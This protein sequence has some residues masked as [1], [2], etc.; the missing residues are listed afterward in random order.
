MMTPLRDVGLGELDES[1]ADTMA[2]GWGPDVETLDGVGCSMKPANN[3]LAK[4]SN[5]D[6][7][8]RDSSLHAWNA[9]ALCPGRRLAL[10]Q[11]REGQLS[12]SRLPDV[13]E[14]CDI[15]EIGKAEVQRLR[16][17]YLQRVRRRC[18][19]ECLASI[20]I[21]HHVSDSESARTSHTAYRDTAASVGFECS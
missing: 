15:G 5:P 17:E 9:A 20:H 8:L 4:R 2:C 13:K 3:L 1:C 18:R 19:T 21:L 11:M 7:V 12:D 16:H 6:L 14:R 10:G